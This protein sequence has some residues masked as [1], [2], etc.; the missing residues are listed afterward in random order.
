MSAKANSMRGIPFKEMVYYD[1]TSK[2]GLRHLTDKTYGNGNTVYAA[3]A[4]DEAGSE[5]YGY[6]VYTTSKYGTHGVHRIIY[7]LENNLE[8]LPAEYVVD[9]IDGNSLNNH[10]DNLRLIHKSSNTRNAKMYS[11]NTSGITG[12]YFDKKGKYDYW[13]ASWM[14]IDGKM[15]TK[16]FSIMK[17]GDEE[18]RNLAINYREKMIA[19]LNAQGAG[20]TERHGT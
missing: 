9:H 20:Y 6:W 12:V 8:D 5:R 13:K 16:S 11:N 1:P 14:K 18:A 2:T 10:I 19:E 4:G 3:Y 15:G 17:Y 7:L